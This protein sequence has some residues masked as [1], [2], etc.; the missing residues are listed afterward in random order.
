MTLSP[1][2]SD[3]ASQATP[4]RPETLL[5]AVFIAV[6]TAT[7]LVFKGAGSQL[8][9]QEFG[10]AFLGAALAKPS[11]WAAIAG[12]IT[13]FVLWITILKR[14]PLSRAY[15]ITAVVYVPVTIGAWLIFG[16]QISA[17]R[18]VGIAAI[19]M[20]VVLIAS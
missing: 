8:E 9:D 18:G 10:F 5:W 14:T 20:G 16:E 19:M 7:Q 2:P 6:A 11:V 12:Y 15:L 4:A 13:M 17:L 1:E 3:A